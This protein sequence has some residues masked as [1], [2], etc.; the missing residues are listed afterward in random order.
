MCNYY[1]VAA[2]LV[3]P[4]YHV[5]AI[6]M[7]GMGSSYHYNPETYKREHYDS[8]EQQFNNKIMLMTKT[9]EDW[10]RQIGLEDF[11]MVA[12]SMGGFITM[13]YLRKFRPKN[14]QG[15]ILLSPAGFTNESQ[16][17]MDQNLDHRLGDDEEGWNIMGCFEKFFTKKIFD[18]KILPTDIFR[19]LPFAKTLTT[20]YLIKFFKKEVLHM[21]EELQEAWV[22]YQMAYS[23]KRVAGDRAMPVFLKYGCYSDELFGEFMPKLM[24]KYKFVVFYGTEDWMDHGSACQKMQKDFPIEKQFDFIFI[25]DSGHV[26]L[27]ENDKDLMQYFDLVFDAFDTNSVEKFNHN[28]TLQQVKCFEKTTADEKL[29]E[30]E[31]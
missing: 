3:K 29:D 20:G 22:D 1:L 23:Y 28:V 25:K 27:M 6:D 9:I 10:R 19:K 4:G 17:Y 30:N 13:H 7:Y 14:V 8:E 26:L 5:Y 31:R 15:V 2:S 24:D 12:H 16:E 21:S 11:Y 18:M